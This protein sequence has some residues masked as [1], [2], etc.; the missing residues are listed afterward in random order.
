MYG[1]P[2]VRALVDNCLCKG[3]GN[4][5]LSLTARETISAYNGG[6]YLYL[7]KIKSATKNIFRLAAALTVNG[8]LG[9]DGIIPV[10]EVCR[11]FDTE[12][13]FVKTS[14]IIG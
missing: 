6:I 12:F 7:G 2:G 11:E 14:A 3:K 4:V 9:T 5:Y 8:Y 10:L 13:L 1:W